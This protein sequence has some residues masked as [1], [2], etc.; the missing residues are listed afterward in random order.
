[1]QRI[2]IV[3]SIL[4]FGATSQAVEDRIVA[5]VNDAVIT[6]QQLDQRF[7]LVL[8]GMPQRVPPAQLKLFYTQVL[9]Q[10]VD[11][12]LQRQFAEKTEMKVP[13][14]M[15]SLTLQ[16][17][18][19]QQSLGSIMAQAGPMAPTLQAQATA[20]ARW[21]R[22]MQRYIVPGV[23][24]S[25]AEVD[26]LIKNLLGNQQQTEWE[27][28]QIFIP[29]DEATGVTPETEKRLA[30][31]A[32]EVKADPSKFEQYAATFNPQANQQNAGYLGWFGS[33]EL[34]PELEHELTMTE[35][36]KP[37]PLVRTQAGL[38]IALVINRRER[39]VVVLEPQEQWRYL[40]F[41]G[42]SQRELRRTLKDLDRPSA[43]LNLARKSADVSDSQWVS[44]SELDKKLAKQLKSKKA[45]EGVVTTVDGEATLYYVYGKRSQFPAKTEQYRERVRERLMNNRVELEARRFMRDLRRVAYVELRI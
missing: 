6:E 10:L 11:E 18:A 9:N 19:P 40:T 24:V 4:L 3:L 28:A 27:V 12:E 30:E 20:Q 45:G 36:G 44:P 23:N 31:I 39:E 21:R 2:F 25:N 7:Q 14:G 22:I 37:T 17:L 35:V 41:K 34:F 43:A 26:R 42:E 29:V 13:A 32:A 15:V 5:V 1:M 8:R 33:G 38:H 16:S